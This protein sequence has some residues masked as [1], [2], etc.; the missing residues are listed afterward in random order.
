MH[1]CSMEQKIECSSEPS[2]ILCLP[3]IT[4]QIQLF[5]AAGALECGM[6]E[7]TMKPR[8]ESRLYRKVES[9]VVLEHVGRAEQP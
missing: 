1:T 6:F 8:G 7:G 9:P 4:I 2:A 5:S 3:L